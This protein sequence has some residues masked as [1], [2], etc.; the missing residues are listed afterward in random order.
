MNLSRAWRKC[1]ISTLLRWAV[2][3]LESCNGAAWDIAATK[4]IRIELRY[5]SGWNEW[6]GLSEGSWCLCGMLG[7]GEPR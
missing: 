1:W 6:K 5:M 2:R 3:E 4:A 7:I